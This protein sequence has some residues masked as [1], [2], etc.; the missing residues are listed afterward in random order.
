[1]RRW[2]L[3]LLCCA[4]AASLATA[5]RTQK[6]GDDPFSET[7]QKYD[8]LKKESDEL[9]GEMNEM[10]RVYDNDPEVMVAE[11]TSDA[12]RKAYDEAF[13]A[14]AAIAQA[15]EALSAAKK[16]FDEAAKAALATDAQAGPVFKRYQDVTRRLEA[17]KTEIRTL[18]DE[19][20]KL[21]KQLETHRHRMSRDPKVARDARAA[22]AA[23]E[24]AYSDAVRGDAAIQEARKA[25]EQAKD[26]H[27]TIRDAKLAADPMYA[28]LAEKY[29]TLYAQTKA[30]QEQAKRQKKRK[31]R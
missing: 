17:I 15:R 31:P 22:V 9:R 19:E 3:E 24:K 23:A 6:L 27:R 10:R 25:S 13:K 16:Q 8:A 2:I 12:A 18:T 14:S 20:R 11:K 7:R 29:K 5:A 4:V 30:L 26:N 28:E 21:R 1:M